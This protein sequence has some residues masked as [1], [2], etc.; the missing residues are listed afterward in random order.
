[1]LVLGLELENLFRAYTGLASARDVLPEEVL[2][3]SIVF[4]PFSIIFHTSSVVRLFSGPILR[5]L[6][7]SLRR[8]RPHLGLVTYN[9]SFTWAS[10]WASL[11]SVVLL[12]LLVGCRGDRDVG[13]GFKLENMRFCPRS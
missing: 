8:L 4:L 10:R 3:H 7:S 5:C 13:L 2:T 11:V 9:S 6:P 1:M 12:R